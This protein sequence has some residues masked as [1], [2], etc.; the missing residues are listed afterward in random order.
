[1]FIS[2]LDVVNACL[3]TM[4]ESPLMTLEEDHSFKAAAQDK[5]RR[6]KTDMSSR[7]LWFNT[8]WVKIVPQADTKHIYI[9]QDVIGVDARSM[10]GRFRV[11]QRGRRLY[12]AGN[13]KY[14]FDNAVTVRIKRD[15]DFDLLPHEAAAFV[16]DDSVLRFQ[17][18]FDADRQK[19]ELYTAYRQESLAL[20]NAEDI[21]QKKHNLLQ[22]A[23]V[24]ILQSEQFMYH[25]HPW[26]PHT[27]YPG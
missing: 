1:M 27:T 18:D 13:N 7:N 4:G 26:H 25:G 11:A 19:R 23:S 14:E 17:G 9:P 6:S 10:C 8:E 12:D 20:L 3:A 22:R 24:R 5:I 15:L 2:E 16:R 21:R